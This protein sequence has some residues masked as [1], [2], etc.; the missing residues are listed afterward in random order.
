MVDVFATIVARQLSSTTRLNLRKPARFEASAAAGVH[1]ASRLETVRSATP[2]SLPNASDVSDDAMA[3]LHGPPPDNAPLTRPESSG[4]L[5]VGEQNDEATPSPD[6]VP[7]RVRQDPQLSQPP[8]QSTV[9]IN[10]DDQQPRASLPAPI[11]VT[12]RPEQREPAADDRP[13]VTA[14]DRPRKQ[15]SARELLQRHFA[16]AL[17][18]AGHLTPQEARRLEPVPTA[19]PLPPMRPNRRSVR[20]DPVDLPASGDVH[21]HIDRVEIGAPPA[22]K[23][24]ATHTPEPPRIDHSAY[25]ER[26][27]RRSQER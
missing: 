15:L 5:P 4:D 7:A 23:Q 20:L 25:L 2:S 21:V 26:Q 14:G 6:H 16:P 19:G 11:H 8:A 24:E 18:A 22:P 27:V 3:S 10:R 12:D 1:R 13:E 9:G 17:V